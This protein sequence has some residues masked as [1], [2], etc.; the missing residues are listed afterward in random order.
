MKTI[1]V[2]VDFS[3]V[4]VAVIAQAA[5]LADA[6][7]STLWL[8]H[9]AAPDPD[10]VGHQAG[11]SNVRQQVAHELRNIHRRLQ[12][13]AQVLRERGLNATALQVQG[14][15]ADTIL[16][17]AERLGVDLIVL[18]SHGHGTLRRA[19]LGSV[20]ERVL[21]QTTCPVLIVPAGRRAG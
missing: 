7:A 14:A 3:P 9:V 19:L 4:T 17:E 6:F 8:V 11:P 1:L 16:Q 15:I 21:H 12:E 13:H 20:S 5:E 10:F 18:G 2:P